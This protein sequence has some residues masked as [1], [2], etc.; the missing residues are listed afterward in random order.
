MRGPFLVLLDFEDRSR[1]LWGEEVKVEAKVET[2]CPAAAS[3]NLTLNL[4]IEPCRS[5]EPSSWGV[6]DEAVPIL[7]KYA[8]QGSPEQA[9]ACYALFCIRGEP[10]DLKSMVDLLKADEPGRVEMP[11]YLNALGAKA[12]PVAAEITQLLTL[13]EFA[14][15]KA[16][17]QAFL[18][19]VEKGEAPVTLMP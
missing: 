17:L 13:E 1:I 12:S 7:E 2:A 11:R 8:V 16:E 6:A 10:D 19:K 3:L 5:T 15:H 4:R 14:E 9:R 18:T